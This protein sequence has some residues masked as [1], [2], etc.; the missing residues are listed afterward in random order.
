MGQHPSLAA[1]S[2]PEAQYINLGAEQYGSRTHMIS[3]T[4]PKKVVYQDMYPVLSK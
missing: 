4:Q 2:A 3:G 1:A